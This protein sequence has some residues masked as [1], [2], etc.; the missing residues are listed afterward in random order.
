MRSA[1]PKVLHE[2]CGRSLLGHTVH[3]ATALEPDHLVV[4]VGH[5]HE[6]VREHLFTEIVPTLPAGLAERVQTAHQAEQRGTGH[7]LRCALEVVPELAGAVV[8]ANGDAPL[9]QVETLETLL[10]EHVVGARSATVLTARVPDPRGLGRIVRDADG[11]LSEIVEERDA[12]DAQRA[13][14]EINS[15][16]FI[17][18]A[19]PLR[20]ALSKLTTEN[21]QQQEYVTDVI[22]LLRESGSSV[23]A[24]RTDDYRETLGANDRLELA[25]LRSLLRDRLVQQWMRAGVT[26]IDPASVW[27]DVSVELAPDVVIQP[28]VQLHGRTSVAQGAQLGPDSTL[29]N[30]VVGSGARVMRSHC[31]QAQIGPD[32]QVG[33]FTYLRPGTRLGSEVKAG[34]YVEIKNSE[35]GTASK[36]PHLTYVGDA[37][38]GEHTNIGAATVFVNY[39]GATKHR[40]RIGSYCRT[41]S[42]TMFVAP[43]TVGDGAYTG[44]GSVITTD[45]PAG[46]LGI[47]R[48]HQH[49]IEGWVQQRRPDSDAAAAATRAQELDNVTTGR[50]SQ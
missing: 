36:V 46:A 1:T 7:A 49:N 31:D 17:F 18:A 10:D 45:V 24:H 28:N 32:A 35:I 4:V 20:E 15:G 22:R 30:T 13:I 3:A 29:I 6:R 39:D 48:A 26:M 12:D 38:I 14:T 40:T 42:D 19:A 47:A 9:L 8:V 50:G 27:L 16:V 5:E 34:A 44:A 2:I 37:D 43:V 23:A 25:H 21:D 41:G 11:G 33:P